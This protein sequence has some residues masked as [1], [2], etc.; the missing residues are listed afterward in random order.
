MD[1]NCGFFT[2]DKVLSLSSFLC[3]TLYFIITVVCIWEST[4][5]V[6]V[7]NWHFSRRPDRC[8]DCCHNLALLA[9]IFHYWELFSEVLYEPCSRAMKKHERS[10][11]ILLT[12][13]K[14]PFY[15]KKRDFLFS[16]AHPCISIDELIIQKY[17]QNWH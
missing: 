16:K 13:W 2:N 8:W 3:I 11:L 7:V 10:N 14:V 6:Y 15:Y 4:R 12:P 1:E 9:H 5:P 17:Y